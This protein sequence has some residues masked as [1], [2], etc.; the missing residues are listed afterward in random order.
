MAGAWESARGAITKAQKKQKAFYDKKTRPPNFAV[1]ERV[2]LFKPAE[3]TGQNRKFARPYHGPFRVCEL[4][5]NTAKICR[6]DR[7]QDDSILVT[8]ARL[9]R[10]PEEIPDMFWPQPTQR[11]RTYKRQRRE[12]ESTTD[13]APEPQQDMHSSSSPEVKSSNQPPS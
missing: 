7:P 10:C 3:K 1:G 11:T 13:R 12:V 8:L 9:R 4:G 5:T 6:V 2:F